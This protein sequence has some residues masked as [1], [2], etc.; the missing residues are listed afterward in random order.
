MHKHPTV[1][2]HLACPAQI[3]PRAPSKSSVMFCWSFSRHTRKQKPHGLSC[4]V[5][6]NT[7]QPLGAP[8]IVKSIPG[9]IIL[10]Q[11]PFRPA[12]HVY[13]DMLYSAWPNGCRSHLLYMHA[14]PIYHVSRVCGTK[15]T[16]SDRSPASTSTTPSLPFF[17]RPPED[18]RQQSVIPM[19]TPRDVALG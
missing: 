1:S 3:T 13:P 14:L 18:R 2:S 8:L 9:R 17:P 7:K 15:R 10:V 11:Q 5:M 19:P 12:A 16:S 4:F 6:Q